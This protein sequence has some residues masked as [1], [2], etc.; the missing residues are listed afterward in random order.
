MTRER[1]GAR[2]G[3][4]RPPRLFTAVLDFARQPEVTQLV[5]PSV[6]DAPATVSDSV[7]WAALR[8]RTRAPGAREL[9][10]SDD[11]EPTPIEGVRGVWCTS[12]QLG[13]RI[14][15]TNL[16]ATVHAGRSARAGSAAP[17]L[18]TVIVTY[19]GGTYISQLRR[20]SWR[21]LFR[22]IDS[23]ITW[24]AVAPLPR[25]N[26]IAPGAGGARPMWGLQN[27]WALEGTIDDAPA[28]VH[29]IKT[30]SSAT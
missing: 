30:A 21:S 6:E 2:D 19:L 17:H 25:T 24:E 15:L 28:V 9:R 8:L 10:F 1:G 11:V 7:P 12:C 18:F 13:R 23:T 16:V 3:S 26:R 20:P 27:V 4:P 22:D 29:V 14:V 5:V